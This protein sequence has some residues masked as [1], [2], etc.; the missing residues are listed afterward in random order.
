[1]K[2]MESKAVLDHHYGGNVSWGRRRGTEGLRYDSVLNTPAR[3]VKGIEA[4][5]SWLSGL[6][7]G[8]F[9]PGTYEFTMDTVTV[10]G[11]V[12]YILWQADCAAAEVPYGTEVREHWAHRVVHTIWLG[13]SC[14]H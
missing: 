11:D 1:M 14:V 13:I 5:R 10:E 2:L 12:A 9:K 7:F 8:L 6:L 4:I 3:S